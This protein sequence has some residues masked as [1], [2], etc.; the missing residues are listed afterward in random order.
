MLVTHINIGLKVS[1][2]L[3]EDFIRPLWESGDY[4]NLA[5]IQE[6]TLWFIRYLQI[7]SFTSDNFIFNK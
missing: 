7:S 3:M 4:A 5:F 1:S 2:L 6:K